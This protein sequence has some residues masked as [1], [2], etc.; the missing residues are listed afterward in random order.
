[1]A[2]PTLTRTHRTRLMQVW[3]SAGWP[4]KDGIEIDLLAAQFLSMHSTP[5]GRETLKLTE[6]GIRVLA[7]ARQRALRAA[8]P[9]DRLAQ[10][11]AE[12]L[13]ASGRIVWRELSL[14]A[15]IDAQLTPEALPSPGEA[16][17]W[18]DGPPE[19]LPA[20]NLWR[21]ARPD[22]FSVRNT[23]VEAYLQPMVHEIKFTR[24]DLLSDLRHEAKRQAYQW[25]CSECYYVFP[26]GVAQAEEI[27]EPFGVWVLHGDPE[28]GHF[29][30]LRPARHFACAL[31]FAVWLAL[32]KSAPMRNEN[33][34]AQAL[35]GEEPHDLP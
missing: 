16:P 27:P 5:D 35:L 11:F 12:L 13:K 10:K 33:E 30:M 24:A 23:T 7:D 29:E 21:M 34:A 14:R 28:V 32:A 18:G 8:S 31:P 19:D 26:A 20:T 15:R 9:H 25:L 17:L 3:R 2:A 22:L 4:C 1:M 6:A